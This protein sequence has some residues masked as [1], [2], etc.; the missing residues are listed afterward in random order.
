LDF[1]AVVL[2]GLEEVGH[3]DAVFVGADALLV[4]VVCGG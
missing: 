1:E 2:A 3:E 4:C